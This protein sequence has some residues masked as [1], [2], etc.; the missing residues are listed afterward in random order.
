M[1][2]VD[3]VAGPS[4]YRSGYVDASGQMFG[5][6][7][8]G[9]TTSRVTGG[10]G[11]PVQPEVGGSGLVLTFDQF[12]F[13]SGAE[14]T[15]SGTRTWLVKAD[16]G[17]GAPAYCETDRIVDAAGNDQ[18][19]YEWCYGIGLSG[20]AN[21]FISYQYSVAN[22]NSGGLSGS[23]LAF[24]GQPVTMPP[25]APVRTVLN[26]ESGSVGGRYNN[27]EP[28]FFSITAWAELNNNGQWVYRTSEGGE[29]L[30][31]LASVP[32]AVVS[33]LDDGWMRWSISVGGYQTQADGSV[34]WEYPAYNQSVE[35]ELETGAVRRY[36]FAEDAPVGLI[37][38]EYTTCQR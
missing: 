21:G 1:R 11:R 2:R 17:N 20:A 10:P 7:E 6:V 19:Q 31:L 38:T 25:V 18:W 13:G 29:D 14:K 36:D 5:W 37:I 35:W 3:G 9:G 26:C 34:Q 8:P 22:G 32:D 24:G 33:E 30:V 27:T 23:D 16:A 12:A 15:G 28:T 4:E